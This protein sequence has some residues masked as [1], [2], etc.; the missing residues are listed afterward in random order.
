MIQQAG[1]FE[2]VKRSMK[3]NYSDIFLWGMSS[4]YSE[5]INKKE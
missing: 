1:I 5:F 3:K 4:K 2:M